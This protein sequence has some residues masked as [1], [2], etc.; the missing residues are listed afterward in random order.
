MT[1]KAIDRATDE[2]RA[3]RLRQ[4][5]RWGEHNLAPFEWLSV[6]G[7]EVGKACQAANKAHWDGAPW[8]GYRAELVQVAAMAIAA[9]ACLD[10]HGGQ[11]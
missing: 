10:R 9:L 4:D 2:V 11:P 8:A 6:L 5:A 1:I 3:E 7:E